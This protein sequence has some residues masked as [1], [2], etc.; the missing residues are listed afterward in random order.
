LVPHGLSCLLD[1]SCQLL[2][3]HFDAEVSLDLLR[4]QNLLA[5]KALV[6]LASRAFH[7]QMRSQSRFQHLVLALHRVE[8]ARLALDLYFSIAGGLMLLGI[9]ESE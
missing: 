9:I 4:G 2:L 6:T 3:S 7:A 1:V 8:A 5:L